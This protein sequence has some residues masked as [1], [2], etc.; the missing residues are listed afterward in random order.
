[1]SA[2]TARGTKDARAYVRRDTCA[3]VPNFQSTAV[4]SL[5][6]I[7]FVPNPVKPAFVLAVRHRSFADDLNCG[8]GNVIAED[9]VVALDVI[10]AH[11]T[12]QNDGLV[13]LAERG[14]A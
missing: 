8:V 5:E 9:R 10:R 12:A 4:E 6:W 14:F 7:D 13:F 1:M 2:G 11:D 3:P